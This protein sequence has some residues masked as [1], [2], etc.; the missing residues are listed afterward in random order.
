MTRHHHT[1]Y[2]EH[3]NPL[4]GPRLI[5]RTAVSALACVLLAGCG[6]RSTGSITFGTFLQ[7]Y[8]LRHTRSVFTPSDTMAWI[9]HLSPPAD[10]GSVTATIA[11]PDSACPAG[12][13]LI[14]IDLP[15]SDPAGKQQSY[16][17]PVINFPVAGVPIP[18]TYT[19]LYTQGTRQLASGSFSLAGTPAGA[20]DFGRGYTR[21]PDGRLYIR[22]PSSQFALSQHIAWV[23]HFAAPAGTR[24]IS[25]SF[26]RVRGCSSTLVLRAD[27]VRLGTANATS[28]ATMLPVS[29]L[30]SLGVAIPGTYIV[31]YERGST[32]LARGEVTLTK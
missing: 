17:I 7:G 31:S 14:S 20:I 29:D 32:F 27:N 13:A 12:R 28:F 6:S 2:K 18:G 24:T 26:H 30:R 5:H 25:I 21:A 9:A 4:P 11:Q 16:Q 1:H 15:V 8:S 10:P 23:A 22:R 3:V 19:L